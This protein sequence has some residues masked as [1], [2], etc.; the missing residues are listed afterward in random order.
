MEQISTVGRRKAAI[1]RVF[2]SAGSGKITI[3]GRDHMEYFPTLPLQFI[4][5]QPF[6][7]LGLEGKYD[8]KVNLDGGGIKGQAEALRLGISR[9]LCEID[10]ENR[11]KLKVN[12]FLTRDPRVVERKKYGQPKARKRFQFS[13]R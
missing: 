2:V 11:P 10:L 6:Q 12:G 5:G 3:N 9:A 7:V 4:V 13:K 8:V 1:A